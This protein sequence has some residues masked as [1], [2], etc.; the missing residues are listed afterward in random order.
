MPHGYHGRILHIY[1]SKRRLE[2]ET[3][4]ESFYRTYM[5]GSA[6]G[7]YYLL[8]NTP[9][10][11]DPLGAENTLT[12][13]AGIMTGAPISGQSR[14]TV[15]AKSPQTGAIGDSQSGGFFPAELKFS[16]YDAVVIHGKAEKPA[17]LWIHDG[18]AELHDAAH[19]WGKVT[20]DVDDIL[21]EELGDAKIQ[22]LQT[23]IAGEN[24]VLYSALMNMS[25]RANGRTG[26]GAVM[27]SKN[28]KAVVVRGKFR[29]S[30]ADSQ[31]LIQHARWGAQNLEDSDVYG[32]GLLGTAEVVGAQ[33]EAGGLPTRNWVSGT[34]KG[35]KAIDGKTMCN[36]LDA[37]GRPTH[38][39]SVVGH[40]TQTCYTQKKSVPCP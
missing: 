21:K 20:G 1:L 33:N 36:A 35:W 4:P 8:K 22:V 7:A 15:V 32:L 13:A 37:E 14:L 9:A 28:L 10:G 11:A 27:A 3:P 5:G 24:L 25:N 2:V 18:E 39:M 38:V 6:F 17:Y 19:L 26:M 31:A 29:P 40:Q 34:F 30:L 23:G 16:G 12:L